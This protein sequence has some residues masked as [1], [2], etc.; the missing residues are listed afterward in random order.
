MVWRLNY[1]SGFFYLSPDCVIGP[2][3]RVIRGVD[4]GFLFYVVHFSLVVN[5]C[6]ESYTGAGRYD[7]E[8]KQPHCE[9]RTK[10]SHL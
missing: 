4:F 5:L 10:S 6:I 1:R 8:K 3:G 7:R 2:V 9:S